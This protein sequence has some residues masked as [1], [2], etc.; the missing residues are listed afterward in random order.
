MRRSLQKGFTLIELSIVLVILGLLVGGILVGQ[1]LIKAASLRS[2]IEQF[3]NYN[4]AAS[5]FRTKYNALP[6]DISGAGNFNLPATGAGT[7]VGLGNG[8]GVIET[9]GSTATAGFPGE[10]LMFFAQLASASL[11]ADPI[12]TTGAA[13]TYSSAAAVAIG[14]SNMPPN[15][16]GG[17]RI[18]PIGFNGLH[19]F[20]LSNFSGSTT[21]TTGAFGSAPADALT[22]TDAFN[23]DSKM[24]DGT[25]NAGIVRPITMSTASVLGTVLPAAGEASA[26]D[27]GA[28]VPAAGDCWNTT[29]TTY[30]TTLTGVGCQLRIRAS[31]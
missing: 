22:P 1:D 13:V 30:A 5:T 12:A 17:G 2:Q 11:I 7:G 24:D 21:A 3:D 14:N 6:G 8:N 20:L 23:I 4:L 9:S 25:P 31:F 19:F 10:P 29:N 26:S 15:K 27:A 16:L 18:Y 28:A